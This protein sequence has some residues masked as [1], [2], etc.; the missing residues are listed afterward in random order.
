MNNLN[1]SGL[2]IAALPGTIHGNMAASFTNATFM[3]VPDI[4]TGVQRVVDGLASVFI[5]EYAFFA[6]AYCPSCKA[7]KFGNATQLAILT[8]Q[9]PDYSV[10]SDAGEMIRFSS[11][12]MILSFLFVLFL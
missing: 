6:T 11:M 7:Y 1:Q 8:R 12:M 2:I 3:P 9:V 5:G 4:L 10:R